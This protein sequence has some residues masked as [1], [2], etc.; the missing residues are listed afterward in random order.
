M[1]VEVGAVGLGALITA[2]ATTMAADVTGVI[3]AS[4]I[5]ALGLFIIP[6]RRRQAKNE[7]HDKLA[8]LRTDLIQ[9]LRAE[10]EKEIERSLLRMSEAI[11]PYTRFVRAETSRS[12][13]VQQELKNARLELENLR[14]IIANWQ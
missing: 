2:L 4:V 11:S 5:A 7:L 14:S 10:F 12:D 3:A 13:Q 1:A 6:A 8:K 9:S